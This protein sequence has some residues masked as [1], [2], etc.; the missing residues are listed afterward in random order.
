MPLTRGH[1]LVIPKLHYPHLPTFPAHISSKLGALLPSLS[2]ALT[3]VTGVEDFNVILNN[4]ER[5]GQTV[6]HVHWHLIPRPGDGKW[7]MFG[8]GLRT[9]DL[10]DEEAAVLAYDIRQALGRGLWNS[11]EA[12]SLSNGR[13]GQD[14]SASRI[15]HVDAASKRDTI[16]GEN[17][18]IKL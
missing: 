11:R 13:H 16:V 12:T 2:R 10:D 5:A 3:E 15:E 1:I 9:E 6:K 17:A 18:R 7:N 14:P 8:R 4:G